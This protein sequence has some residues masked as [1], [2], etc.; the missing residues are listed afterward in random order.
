MFHKKDTSRLKETFFRFEETI[1]YPFIF[2]RKFFEKNEHKHKIKQ[3]EIIRFWTIKERKIINVT[4][5]MQ[6]L[7]TEMKSKRNGMNIKR[8]IY[9]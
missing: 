6:N 1:N 5:S 3:S 7:P 4:Q 9:I 8:F 2:E